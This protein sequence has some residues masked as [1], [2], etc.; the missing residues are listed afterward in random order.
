MKTK[1]TM[2]MMQKRKTK[3]TVISGDS[4][5]LEPFDLWKKALGPRYGDRVPQLVP[6]PNGAKG[7]YLFCGKET[8]LV[9][10]LVSADGD[11][12]LKSLIKAGHDPVEREKLLDE[13]GV[14]AEVLNS[15]WTLYAM[16]IDDPELRRACCAVFNDW[17]AHFCSHNP[18]RLF[19]VAMIPIDDVAWGVREVERVA[20]LGLKGVTIHAALPDGLPPYRD[21][22][23]DRFW[24]ACES[25]GLPV[26]LH[27]VTGRVRDPFTYHGKEEREEA[28]ASFIEMFQEVM[29]VLARDFIFGGILDR[30]PRLKLILSEYEASW[31]PMFRYRLD[32][33]ERF[34]GLSK[35]KKHA[36]Q[37]LDD[38]VYCGIIKD[39]FAKMF[40][41]EI[42]IGRL[43]WGS[44]FPHPNCTFPDTLKVID[45]ILDGIPATDRKKILEDNVRKAYNISA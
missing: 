18:K 12:R 14:T 9:D 30:H 35:L 3:T 39:P 28:P 6:G 42:G 25:L 7:A 23:Y 29:P 15:T 10:E 43:I 34:P 27:I 40:R 36:R 17:L 24:R 41:K 16:R 26:T 2:P 44:D 31:I 8:V 19:G 45:K 37:Y 21:K 33:I 13:D 4:H 32:R 38:N 1:K 22:I 5:V 20:K 11:A